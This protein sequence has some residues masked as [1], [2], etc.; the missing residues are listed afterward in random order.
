MSFSENCMYFWLDL[1]HVGINAEVKL[2]CIGRIICDD[3]EIYMFE[4][5]SDEVEDI[6]ELFSR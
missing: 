3:S 5:S 2:D 4:N 6:F 1:N